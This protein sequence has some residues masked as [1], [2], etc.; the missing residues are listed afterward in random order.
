MRCPSVLPNEPERL[1][2][3]AQYG[4]SSDRPLPSLDP[5]VQIAAHSFDVPAAAVNM[6]GR[7]EVFLAASTGIG[8]FDKSRDVSF[9]AHAITQDDVLV[10]EDARLDSRFHDNPL[11]VGPAPIRFYAG[12]AVRSPDGHAL[13]AL[14]VIDSSPRNSFSAEDRA[15][16]K[17]MAKLVSDRLELQRLQVAGKDSAQGFEKIAL[18]SPNGILCFKEAGIITGTN[19]AAEKIFAL[20]AE[21][22]VGRP[23]ELLLPAW[24]ASEIGRR[25]KKC[26]G[27]DAEPTVGE[28]LI[29]LRQDGSTFAVEVAWS[30]WLEG[31]QSNFALVL[32]DVT[33]QRRQEDELKRLA[34]FD[35]A[36]SLPNL[37]LF[38]QRIHDETHASRPT[39]VLAIG[40]SG[41]HVISDTLGNSAWEEALRQIAARLRHCVRETDTVG[42]LASDQFGICLRGI[43]D[44]IRAFDAAAAAMAAVTQPVLIGGSEVSVG[45][46]CGVA[47]S[48][49][50][51]REAEELVGNANL[52]LQEARKQPTGQSCLF[53]PALRMQ[54]VAKRMFDAE[55]HRAVERDELQLYFQPQVRLSDG[56]L[57]GAEALLRWNH[58]ERGVLSPA[59]FL[60]ALEASSLA[61]VVGNWVIDT[62]CRQAAEWRCEIT[63]D[64]RMSINL[65]AAQFWGGRLRSIVQEAL[66]RYELPGPAIE[67]EITE[68]T[69]LDDEELF[70]P[71]LNGLSEDGVRLA[72]DDFGTG[73]ASLSLLARYPVTD[74]KI[75]KS[76]VQKAFT[77]DRDRAIVQAITALAH[78]LELKVIAEGV[79]S[80]RYLDFC[81]E[82]GCD[83]AQGFFIG[84]PVAASEFGAA[85][86]RSLRQSARR[87]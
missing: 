85:W 31:E 19:P 75:D 36:T 79:E 8:D 44:P 27:L 37:N 70:L 61:A 21:Q 6:I 14:C 82:I 26:G 67:L 58:P 38:R 73:F 54:A 53:V 35:H 22:I 87:P 34:N 66:E 47:L 56:F 69:V 50:H 18:S 65:F 41:H 2:A 52:A 72:F 16:L 64:F 83:E 49:S 76:F 32:R 57:T 7:D 24:K 46:H 1:I 10:V 42:R 25:L 30:A 55:L 5:V 29:A 39:A 51:G 3:L 68:T 11:V 40:L 15:R 12:V 4:L 33:E 62:A 43:G 78:Q 71:L 80:Q 84:R 45:V 23:L 9:C 81:R 20:T 60:P 77:S 48:P 28:D 86:Q 59:A 63:P 74:L 17:E 13:G